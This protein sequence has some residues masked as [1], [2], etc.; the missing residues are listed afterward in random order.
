MIV[1][2]IL[3]II[4]ELTLE[5]IIELTLVIIIE[6]TLVIII[7]LTLVIIIELTLV[8]IIE[9]TLVI[10]DKQL[11]N[12]FLRG[13]HLHAK[14]LIANLMFSSILSI[15][16]SSVIILLACTGSQQAPKFD[17]TVGQHLLFAG[18][19]LILFSH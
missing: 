6:L 8:I 10:C 9:L 12:M 3:V 7:E 14:G 18:S 4:I 2:I 11:E 1:E 19:Y 16:Q 15:I 17:P 5:I 13:L